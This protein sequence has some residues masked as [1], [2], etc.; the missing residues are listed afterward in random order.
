MLATRML[1]TVVS[2]VKKWLM[3]LSYD[4]YA[5]TLIYHQGKLEYFL[6]L[7]I[8]LLIIGYQFYLD[9][10]AKGNHVSLYSNFEKKWAVV[11]AVFTSGLYF[12][13]SK[14]HAAMLAC[15]QLGLTPP[16]KN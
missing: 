10:T 8:C 4:V 14:K 9:T 12:L 2:L 6:S 7:I 3:H 16:R 11:K 13:L 1:I 5:F 15:K